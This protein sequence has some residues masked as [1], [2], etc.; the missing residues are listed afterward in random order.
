MTLTLHEEE[1]LKI[2]GDDHESVIGY[3]FPILV[4]RDLNESSSLILVT[5]TE[6]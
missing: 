2:Y 4:D 5:F 1:S 3:R 6:P